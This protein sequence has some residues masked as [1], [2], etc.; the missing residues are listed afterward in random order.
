[1]VFGV[2]KSKFYGKSLK[3]FTGLSWWKIRRKQYSGRLINYQV[4]LLKKLQNFTVN[5]KLSHKQFLLFYFILNC[6]S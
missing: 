4:L 2:S 5:L 3:V 6:S 1:M